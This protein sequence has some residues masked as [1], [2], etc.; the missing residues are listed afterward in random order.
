MAFERWTNPKLS[1]R[2]C[3]CEYGIQSW[4]WESAGVAKRPREPPDI[5]NVTIRNSFSPTSAGLP[6]AQAY[7]T[8]PAVRKMS[9]GERSDLLVSLKARWQ[10][11]NSEYQKLPFHVGTDRAR[12]VPTP[13]NQMPSAPHPPRSLSLSL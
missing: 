9:E 1:R 11:T 2:T 7:N 13:L 4:R 3:T 6:C 12:C 5:A 10:H 8:E